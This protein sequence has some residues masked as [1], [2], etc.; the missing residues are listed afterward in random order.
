MFENPAGRWGEKLDPGCEAEMKNPIMN[1]MEIRGLIK[2][3][4]CNICTSTYDLSDWIIE[5]GKVVNTP[6]Y[7]FFSS[8]RG[9][10]SISFYKDCVV[11]NG[12]RT[13]SEHCNLEDIIDQLPEDIKDYVIFNLD[14]FLKKM[15]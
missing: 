7:V 8:Y 9:N 15:R 5:V 3:C 2:P 6:F 4:D 1:D 14:V 12:V 13:H 10:F 11:T